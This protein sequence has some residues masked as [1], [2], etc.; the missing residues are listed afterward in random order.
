VARA[1]ADA[2]APGRARGPLHVAA[3]GA[4]L[5]VDGRAVG[6][7]P[8]ALDVPEGEHLV[9]A[10]APGFRAQ[11][12]LVD[13]SAGGLE[14]RLEL[15]EDPVAT[16]LAALHARPLP[17]GVA[18]LAAA[19]GVD[20]VI[21]VAAGVDAGALTLV[22]ERLDARGCSTGV[23]TIAIGK[24]GLDAAAAELASELARAPA[25]CPPATSADGLSI[26]EAGPVA[27]PRPIPP[28]PAPPPP[29]KPRFYERPWLWVGLLVVTSAAVGATAALVTRSTTSNVTWNPASF[30]GP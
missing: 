12:A 29:R 4:Q 21:A 16:A 17:A 25:E 27:H 5:S 18:A 2:V 22:G 7:S 10:S 3:A 20:G 13:V 14:V 30:N 8:A 19:L 24:R 9:R 15:D 26:V 28:P 1:F 23:V 6:P 11:A